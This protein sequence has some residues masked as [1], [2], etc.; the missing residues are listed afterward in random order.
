MTHDSPPAPTRQ[1]NREAQTFATPSPTL[2]DLVLDASDLAV[3]ILETSNSTP[4]IRRANERFCAL[5][6]QTAADLVGQA[7]ELLDDGSHPSRTQLLTDAIATHTQ[8]TAVLHSHDRWLETTISPVQEPGSSETL[9]V[10]LRDQTRS[11]LEEESRA[12]SQRQELLGR[13]ASGVAHDFN[14]VLSAIMA[15]TD[16]AMDGLDDQTRM[17][18][19]REVEQAA[20]RGSEIT[21]QLLAFS[22]Y[23]GE[24]APDEPIDLSQVIE[25][26]QPMMAHLVG[27]E[28]TV[29]IRPSPEPV[30]ALVAP[31]LV[32]QVVL[33]LICISCDTRQTGAH[34]KIS[35]A[36]HTPDASAHKTQNLA[37]L[38]IEE[39]QPDSD[40]TAKMPATSRRALATS[41][42][43]LARFGGHLEITNTPTGRSFHVDFPL[44]DAPPKALSTWDPEPVSTTHVSGLTCLLVEDGAP[45]REA[46]S[47][48]LRDV[49][50]QVIEAQNAEVAFRHI[51]EIGGGLDLVI[52]DMVL[53]GQNGAAVIQHAR[54]VAP[55]AHFLAMTGA[56][57]SPIADAGI[58]VI[59]KPFSPKALVRRA[60]DAVSSEPATSR[61]LTPMLAPRT[62]G[63][64]SRRLSP[65]PTPFNRIETAPSVLLAEDDEVIRRGLSAHL[66]SRGFRVL[67]AGTGA[68]A[69]ALHEH[70]DVD[71]VVAD[72]H[73]PDTDGL[74]L[75]TA[76]RDRDPLVP[77]LVLTGDPT[78]LTAQKAL[79]AHV[80]AYLTKPIAPS[81]FV[82]EVD[83]SIKEGQ[84]AKLQ[85]KLLMSKVGDNPFLLDIEGTSKNFDEAMKTLY[86]VYQPIVRAHDNSIFA[87]EALLRFKSDKFRH[88]GELLA[89]ADTLGRMEEL[90]RAVR[91]KVAETIRE[92]PHR[93]EL[94]FVNLHPME[95]RSDLLTAPDEP[96]LEYASRV[97][98]EV[99]ERAQLET[100][101][102]LPVILEGLQQAGYRVALD[103]LGEGYA[104]LSWLVKLTPDIA[105]LDMSL[106]RDIDSSRLKRE[107]VSSM[108]G[109]CRRAHTVIVAEGV[110]TAEEATVLRDLGCDLL[111]GY[112][113]ARPDLPFPEVNT[114]GS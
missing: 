81:A 107:L 18:D 53:P 31:Q 29:D 105:K 51:D 84:V 93:N 90:G 65:D 98:L 61:M 40:G 2:L 24:Q 59:W 74:S 7:F 110:E 96:L 82:E 39:Q 8:A 92:N 113:F 102:N 11:R 88:P 30:Y 67:Q 78:V 71:L 43:L 109:V 4:T 75:L 10:L 19:L 49:G 87:F 79:R 6:G 89:A 22:T 23:H 47:R 63:E 100:P 60:V 91:T 3:A 48:A 85:Q 52:C 25:R 27:Y 34:I 64:P 104:G 12:T 69:I 54:N 57:D 37:C 56:V 55:H 70:N 106:V 50:F 68:Q 15:Y 108:V 33:N 35:L 46:C 103:D 73:L 76:V 45:L 66:E 111:Q 14:N 16:F 36:R 62:K 17:S 83:R 13:L 86:M 95:L 72:L 44:S 99:T 58:E 28:N 80:S 38:I 97:I 21:R 1:R 5:A 112:Y 101:R 9:V 26:I 32:E 114:L 20:E 42:M 77:T 41:E 94:F